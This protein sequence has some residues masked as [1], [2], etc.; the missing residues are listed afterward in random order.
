M[1][2]VWKEALAV[3]DVAQSLGARRNGH[4]LAVCQNIVGLLARKETAQDE[5]EVILNKRNVV[6]F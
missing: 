1:H 2:V 4:G 5:S 3:E 6:S